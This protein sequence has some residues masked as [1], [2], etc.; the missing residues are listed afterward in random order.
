MLWMKIDGNSIKGVADAYRA[1][2]PRPASRSGRSGEAK[3]PLA[4]GLSLSPKAQEANALK[5]RLTEVPEFR[6]ELVERIK[7][8]LEAGTYRVPAEELAGRLLEARVL[9]P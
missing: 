9:E 5:A 1:A 4:D 7:A 6:A 2:S 8:Q 3:A